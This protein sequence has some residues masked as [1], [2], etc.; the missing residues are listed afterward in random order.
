MS[1]IRRPVSLPSPAT[2]AAFLSWSVVTLSGSSRLEPV[3]VLARPTLDPYVSASLFESRLRD[4]LRGPQLT[5]LQIK[6]KMCPPIV[7]RLKTAD[8]ET[9]PRSNQW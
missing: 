3:A 9:S 2:S 8:D 4:V 5:I 6:I 1:G 7:S